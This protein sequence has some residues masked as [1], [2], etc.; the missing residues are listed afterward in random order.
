[1]FRSFVYLDEEKMY[2]Y[3]RQIDKEYANQPSEV[4]IRK[5]KGG[6]LSVYGIGLGAE[7]EIEERRN[8]NKDVFNDYD[9]FEKALE[10]LESREYF[11]FVLNP[12]YDLNNVPKMCIIRINGGFVIPEQFDM[13]SMAQAFMPFITSQI[14]TTN[15]GECDFL[16]AFLGN[17]SAD[18][19]FLVYD[20][21]IV[22]SGK[23]S[24]NYLL[25]DYSELE[26]YNEQDVF[27]LCKVIGLVK[28]NKV[29]VFNPLKDFIKLPR[30]VRRG[31][32]SSA[33]DGFESIYV[34]GPDLKVEVIA[35]YK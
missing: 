3:L 6:K 4:N 7:H 1:M 12:E 30:A 33:K 13:Y 27:M 5:T 18:I 17:A 16:E 11:D 19:P 32:D 34:D 2:S 35:I 22:I 29:E 31:M 8:H 10:C 15:N 14:Q 21:D 23:L 25:E 9:R 26:D 24:T 28:K 20:E